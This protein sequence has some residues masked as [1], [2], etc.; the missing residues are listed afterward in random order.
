VE[1]NVAEERTR[2]RWSEALQVSGLHRACRSATS[3]YFPIHVSY[4]IN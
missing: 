2:M 3:S 4:S 1:G